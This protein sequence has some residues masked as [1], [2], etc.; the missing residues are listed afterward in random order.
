[1]QKRLVLLVGFDVERLV[2][3]LG[4]LAL[5]VLDG[6]FVLLAGSLVGFGRV[7]RLSSLALVAASFS[8]MTATRLGS[9][10]TSSFSRRISL[11]AAC[12][13]KRF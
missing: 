5:E 12:N 7:L 13:S 11:S 4:D 10:A 6:G 1:V 8:S 3:V 9:A 2:A